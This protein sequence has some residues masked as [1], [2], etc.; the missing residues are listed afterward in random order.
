MHYELSQLK[1]FVNA[2]E[3]VVKAIHYFIDGVFY[4]LFEDHT[5]P[6]IMGYLSQSY[7]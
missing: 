3:E 7:T 1:I 5:A 4:E 6:E 2:I